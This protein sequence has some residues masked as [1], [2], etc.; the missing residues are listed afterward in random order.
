[1]SATTTSRG[2]PLSSK[3]T[4]RVPSSRR[5]PVVRYLT[6][7]DLPGLDFD[8]DLVAALEAVEERGR[9]D[10]AGVVVRAVV[11]LVVEVD[12]RVHDVRDDVDVARL[13]VDFAASSLRVASKSIFG[14]FAPGGL[15]ALSRRRNRG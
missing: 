6:I 1:L 7:S 12:L 4:V 11:L 2:W 14:S 13:V 8:G 15:S 10:D 5:M 3:K 9:R